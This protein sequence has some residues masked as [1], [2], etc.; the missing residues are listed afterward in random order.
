VVRHDQARAGADGEYVVTNTAP[1]PATASSNGEQQ[2]RTAT[3]KS[4][5]LNTDCTDYADNN[6]DKQTAILSLIR[7]GSV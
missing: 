5:G 3:E 4:N 1:A 6:T 2:Q 7:V